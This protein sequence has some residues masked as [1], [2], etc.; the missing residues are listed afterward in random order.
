MTNK[1]LQI[2]PT[3]PNCTD[4]IGDF[5]LLLAE[6]M[7]K[8]YQITTHFLVFQTNLE[9]E[10]NINGFPITCLES[11]NT[12]AFLSAIPKDI[13]TVILQFS[14]FPYFQ[15][16]LRGMFGIGTPFWLVKALEKT[17]NFRQ[18]KLIVI[19]HELPKLY[20]RQIYFFNF[21]NPIHS[22]VS[23]QI[24]KLADVVSTTSHKYQKILES[25]LKQPVQRLF[26][27][28]TIGEPNLVPPL[29]KR[30]R[31]L[32]IFGGS[33]RSRVYENALSELIECCQ[34]LKIEEV[35][36]I[37]ASLDLQQ[38]YDFQGVNFHELGFKN[39]EEIE[40]LML[41]SIAGV[42]D[43]TPFPGD[44][45]KSSVLAAYCA[46]GLVPILTQ[47]NPSEKDGLYVDKHYLTLNNCTNKIDLSQLQKL[48]DNAY[49][50]YSEHSFPEIGKL[51]RNYIK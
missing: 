32:I 24:A 41:N 12:E 20:W 11:H 49:Q 29:I 21:L 40:Q 50:W 26:I 28:S 35:Y 8:D 30:K 23:R 15:T 7:Y 5:S 38:S 42:L 14:G 13:S 2:I 4:G 16:N 19:F 18:I 22:Q 44:L 27:P 31:C 51:V 9:V 6:Q 3:P 37:G 46:H 10:E 17:I 36:D 25:W 34:S 33:A 47:Y 45:S 48:A 39:K 43:Y 1:I